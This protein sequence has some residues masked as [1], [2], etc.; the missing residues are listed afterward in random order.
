MQEIANY[1]EAPLKTTVTCT[2]KYLLFFMSLW[3]ICNLLNLFHLSSKII[4]FNYIVYPIFSWP[5]ESLPTNGISNLIEIFCHDENVHHVTVNSTLG[6]HYV[7]ETRRLCWDSSSSYLISGDQRG[8]ALVLCTKQKRDDW[9]CQHDDAV[10][11][12]EKHL[13]LKVVLFP[14]QFT[15]G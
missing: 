12:L 9:E 4:L 1:W 2:S 3:A 6:K 15:I 14:I 5:D 11:L 13:G 7:S 8:Q 10:S